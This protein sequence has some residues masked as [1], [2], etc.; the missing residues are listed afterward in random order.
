MTTTKPPPTEKPPVTESKLREILATGLPGAVQT[1]LDQDP[2]LKFHLETKA[3]GTIEL[4]DSLTGAALW[5]KKFITLD[6]ET[7]A[8]KRDAAKLA[9]V[10]DEVLIRGE[11][12]TGKELVARAMLGDKTGQFKR[13]NC[14][15]M[16]EGLLE[17]ELFGH[18]KGAF[19]NADNAKKGMLFE[20]ANGV[21]FMDE[22][23]DMPLILQS[24]LLT[25]LQ[26]IDGKCYARPVGSNEEKEITCRFVFATHRDLKD[27]VERGLFRKDLY[28]RIS[29]FELYIKPL[30]E[31]KED[32]Q[33]IVLEIGRLLGIEKKAEEFLLKYMD[34]F[35]NDELSLE[36]NVRS[37]EQYLKRYNLLGKV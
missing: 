25:I 2:R 22:I 4:V 28:A 34:K 19:T 10:G 15:A 17:S 27:M 13:I 21:M 35:V 26:P 11:T 9:D 14:S 30:K 18:T 12:G 32:I 5:L 23:G 20:A 36:F 8:M 6:D 1:L 7:I 3:D 37:I 16:P 29:T 33:P 24:K 31:R